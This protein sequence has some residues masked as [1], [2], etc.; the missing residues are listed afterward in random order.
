MRTPSPTRGLRA[1]PLFLAAL[2]AACGGG[3]E[4]TKKEAHENTFIDTA[5]RLALAEKDARTL[6]VHDLDSNAVEA[7]YTLDHVPSALYA[8]PGGRYALAVQRTQDQVQMVDAGVWQEDHGDHLHDYRQASKLMGSKLTGV[9]P[10]HYDVQAG[11]QAAFFMDGSSAANPVQN[12]GVRVFT[13][14]S[15]A[16][17]TNGGLVASLDLNAPIHG[18]AEPVNDKLLAV[19]RASDAPDTLPT[20]LTLYTR[21]GSGYTWA[22][23]IPTRCDGM[24]GSSSSGNT[25]VAGCLGGMLVVRHTGASSTDDGRLVA[26]PLRVGTLAG[27]VRLP[28]H[29]IGIATEGTAPAPVTTRFYALNGETGT[30]SDFVPQGWETGRQRRA[31]GFDRSG[32]RFFIL[33]DQGSLIVAQRSGSAWTNLT[34][35][36]G[37]IPRMPAAAPWP[38]FAANG[39]K[40]EVYLSDPEARQL[41]VIDSQTGAI[42]ARRDLG[43]VPSLITWTGITR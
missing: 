8:S 13:D 11:K 24:H 19:S 14:A 12:A 15:L 7:S 34:R 41:V 28:D 26:T 38:A 27:H 32:Q 31:H 18:L 16:S 29:F 39:A 25:T 22:R 4:E 30:V 3:V 10:T 2:L 21:S 1:A 23:K 33:D 37:A 20:H 35:V 36:S 17:G 42:K 9:R 6:R 40:D 5:G 43:F